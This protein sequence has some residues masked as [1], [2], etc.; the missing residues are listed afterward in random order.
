MLVGV[1]WLGVA[2][3]ALVRL[4]AVF[5]GIPARSDIPLKTR[6]TPHVTFDIV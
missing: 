4:H 5:G 6:L 1:R 2:M 3:W